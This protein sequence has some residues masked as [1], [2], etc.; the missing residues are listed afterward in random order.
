MLVMR[1]Y[2]VREGLEHS[3]RAGGWTA[4]GPQRR[5]AGRRERAHCSAERTSRPGV[6]MSVSTSAKIEPKIAT[7]STS[8]SPV[9]SELIPRA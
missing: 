8:R 2:H 7:V 1:T 6:E 3:T 5:W 4:A 9:S